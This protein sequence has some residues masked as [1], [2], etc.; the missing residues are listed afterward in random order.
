[1]LEIQPKRKIYPKCMKGRFLKR[2]KCQIKYFGFEYIQIKF[3]ININQNKY[4]IKYFDI[5]EMISQ[6]KFMTK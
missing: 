2:I 3:Q 1:M 4:Q 5:S 6:T